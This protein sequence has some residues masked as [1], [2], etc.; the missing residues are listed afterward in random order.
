MRNISY[1]FIIFTAFRSRDSLIL[2]EILLF[3]DYLVSKQLERSRIA[4][5]FALLLVAGIYVMNCKLI[6]EVYLFICIEHGPLRLGDSREIL[7]AGICNA[8]TQISIF[9]KITLSTI[10]IAFLTFGTSWVLTVNSNTKKGNVVFVDYMY[11]YWIFHSTDTKT[12][13]SSLLADGGC[14]LFNWQLAI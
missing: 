9:W 13:E 11:E 3:V 2:K 6:V 4:S 14:K 12:V 5:C 8:Q 1:S 7:Q 10:F